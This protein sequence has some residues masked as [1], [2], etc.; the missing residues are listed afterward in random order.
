MWQVVALSAYLLL[1]IV[2]LI[3]KILL[4]GSV[5]KPAVFAF[6]TATLGLLALLFI[7]FGFSWPGIEQFIL[8]VAAGFVFILALLLYYR[9]A[10]GQEISRVIPGIAAF[11][12]IFT[13]INSFVFLGDR[14]N[15]S[16]IL[17]F[18]FLVAGGILV[19]LQFGYKFHYNFK[20]LGLI[21]LAAF[22]FSVAFVLT[23]AVFN[24]QS[25]WSGFIWM[26]IGGFLFAV[27]LL[28]FAGVRQAI[29]SNMASIGRG[30]SIL[31]MT[32][33]GLAAGAFILQNY[34]FS[35]GPLA[36]VNA[37]ESFRY[38]FLLILTVIISKFYSRIL[39]ERVSKVVMLQKFGA[40]GLVSVGLILLF[41]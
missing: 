13:L 28:F 14:F 15:L 1:A 3:D 27:F 18:A 6:Y 24:E 17:A 11:L 36:L 35:L 12:P 16:Q 40:I 39:T 41:L 19:T 7:P 22:T 4:V 9:I 23:K 2:A 20:N 31:F 37:L 32:N 8:A 5:D 10:K 29:K 34:A 30:G 33:Q 25:F 21:L 26:R 38:V